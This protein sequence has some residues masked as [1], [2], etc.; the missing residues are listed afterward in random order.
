MFLLD[1]AQDS[2]LFLPPILNDP[3]DLG[4]KQTCCWG[5]MWTLQIRLH[6]GLKPSSTTY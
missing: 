1:P 5:K 6:P 3:S 2:G 4:S